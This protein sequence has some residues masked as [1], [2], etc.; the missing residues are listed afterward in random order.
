MQ[1]IRHHGHRAPAAREIVSEAVTSM[2]LELDEELDVG[3]EAEA[4]GSGWN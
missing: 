3:V 2:A 1:A 4:L